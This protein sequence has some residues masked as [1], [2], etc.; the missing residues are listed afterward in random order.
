LHPSPGAHL[1]MVAT[2]SL[3]ERDS[4]GNIFQFGQHSFWP[5]GVAASSV[6]KNSLSVNV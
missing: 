5:G 6:D 4:P 1:A 2:L 3:R